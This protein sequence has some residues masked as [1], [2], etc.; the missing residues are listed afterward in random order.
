MWAEKKSTAIP[1]SDPCDKG[2]FRARTRT[3]FRA[4]GKYTCQRQS[5]EKVRTRAAKNR[6]RP[7]IDNISLKHS[8][9]VREFEAEWNGYLATTRDYEAP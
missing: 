4:R 1:Q 8:L 2:I 3:P 6:L 5:H 9:I 7:S